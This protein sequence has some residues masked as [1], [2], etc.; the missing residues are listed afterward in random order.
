MRTINTVD[1]SKVKSQKSKLQFKIQ[2][3]FNFYFLL[4]VLPFA[5]LLFSLPGYTQENNLE[6]A[7]NAV[8]QSQA[9][10]QQAVKIY[11]GLIA[12]GKD[13]DNLHFR[14]GKLYYDHGDF[15]Q[16]VEEFKKTAEAQ[17]KKFL[18]IAYYRL[19]SFTDAFEAFR[20][21]LSLDDESGYYYGL[22]AEKLN[23]FDQALDIYRKIKAEEFLQ[24]ALERANLIEK[25][26]N[27]LTIKDI[28]QET[29]KIINASPS[30]KE[31]PQAGALI[32]LSDEKVEITAE[33][34]QVSEMH[35]IVKI[36][37]ER[38]KEDF[39]E[40]HIDYDTTYEK[41]ELEYARTIKPDGTVVD[42]GTRHIRDVSKYLN[43]PLYSN[44]HIYIISFPE[45]TAGAVIEYKVKIYRNQLVN[46]K[47]FVLAYPVQTSDPVIRADFSLALPKGK[48]LHIKK[49]NEEYN[50]FS[51]D[52]SPKI[53]E[54]GGRIT[55]RWQFKNIPQVIPESN[56]PP[57]VEINPTIIL[58]SFNSWQDIYN[59]WWSLASGKIK[60]DNAVKDK[61]KELIKDKDSAEAKTRA[62]YNFCA[63]EIRYVAV[64]Y[65]QAG[66]EPHKAEDVFKNKY[67]DCKDQ[68]ILLVTM[69]KE[70]GFEASP[71]LISTKEYYN[72]NADFPSMLFNHAIAV[73]SLGE[74]IIFMD[75]TA[76]TCSF[77]DLPA[78]DQDR[79]VLVFKEEGYQIQDIPFY[80]AA[81]NLVKQALNIKINLDEAIDAERAV[82]TYGRYDQ[83]QRYWLLY[84]PPELIAETLRE[85]IQSISIGAKLKDYRIKN[86]NDLNT[87]VALEYTFS[88]PEYLTNAGPLRIMPQLSNLDTTLVAKDKRKFAL[89]F[90]VLDKQET[91]FVIAIPDKFVIKY[92]PESINED[93]PWL[94][95][96]SEYTQDRNKVQL[97]QSTELKKNIIKQAEY[98]DFKAFFE[99]L[100]KRI[101]QRVILEKKNE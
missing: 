8:E 3:F 12:Q 88:G 98:R 92:I 51:A 26:A 69:L 71:V 93:S 83:A 74:K 9:Y 61:V 36:L 44:A 41:V 90:D 1:K 57:Q 38:G 81:H 32:L 49:L 33:N 27:L 64:E 77:D 95:F 59:W 29:Y 6:Q 45:I 99:K 34:T 22:T 101:K 47:D 100:A 7:E 80:P 85:K 76:E 25:Q 50:D 18:A 20:K 39:S 67:G 21:N 24:Q 70:A 15:K 62:I 68:A 28:S 43:F 55:Y 52:L 89:E 73:V 96:S 4:V 10:Y 53:D 23:L 58:S 37:N 91:N 82:F 2:K 48:S 11:Q 5:F 30:E 79:R 35:Y 86:L 66:Y 72:L 63:K 56:M 31:Y 84:T 46:K 42:V 78:G 40:S 13:L 54:L 65:G 97:K 94:K 75:P 19:G 87:P 17:A 14:L 16:A 60:A